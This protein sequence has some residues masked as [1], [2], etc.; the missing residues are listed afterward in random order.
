MLKE[1][2]LV[3]VKCYFFLIFKGFTKVIYYHLTKALIL[4]N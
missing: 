4:R 2:E 1:N 3:C